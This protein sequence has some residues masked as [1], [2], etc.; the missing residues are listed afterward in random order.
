MTLLNRTVVLMIDVG[1]ETVDSW[2]YWGGGGFRVP[3]LP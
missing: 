3:Q 2:D 1:D